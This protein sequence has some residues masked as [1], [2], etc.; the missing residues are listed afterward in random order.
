M[1]LYRSTYFDWLSGRDFILEISQHLFILAWAA[2]N[3]NGT[4][5]PPT[6]QQQQQ[7]HT[8]I[9]VVLVLPYC[10]SVLQ[11]IHHLTTGTCTLFSSR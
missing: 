5:I 11:Q 2:F 9:K 6:P 4:P 8:G 10:N 3:V 7:H 1:C